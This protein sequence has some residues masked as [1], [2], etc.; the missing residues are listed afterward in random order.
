MAGDVPGDV[1]GAWQITCVVLA[2][3][4]RAS[5]SVRMSSEAVSGEAWS[6]L[7]SVPGSAGSATGAPLNGELPT[8]DKASAAKRFGATAAFGCGER[9]PTGPRRAG[10]PAVVVKQD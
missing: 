8:R 9:P 4:G 6:C 7:G 2:D 5:L 3:P 1:A 10:R